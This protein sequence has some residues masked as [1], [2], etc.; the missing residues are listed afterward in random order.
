MVSEDST[1]RIIVFPPARVLTNTLLVLDLSLDVVDGVGRLDL[2][3]DGLARE[4]L[5]KNLH[6][7]TKTKDKVK[8]LKRKSPSLLKLFANKD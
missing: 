4:G 3:S 1:S 8:P 2:Q 7:S 6:A 5:N